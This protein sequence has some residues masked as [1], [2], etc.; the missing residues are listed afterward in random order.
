MKKLFGGILLALCASFFPVSS[1]LAVDY[2]IQCFQGWL[3]VP[4]TGGTYA[5]PTI[6]SFA[7]E[8]P[9]YNYANKAYIAI[10]GLDTAVW[11]QDIQIDYGGQYGPKFLGAWTSLGGA[12]APGYRAKIY[13]RWESAIG[14]YAPAIRVVGTDLNSYEVRWLT[15]G[16]WGWFAVGVG[17]GGYSSVPTTTG[18][19]L[20]S[21]YF[22]SD[23]MEV[24]YTFGGTNPPIYRCS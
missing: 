9:A 6:Q 3:N 8:P 5:G 13:R 11:V 23:Y 22:F 7:N 18:V 16:T 12:I 2:P 19:E 15:N 21:N 4:P 1:A 24:S 10:K 20:D 17:T 14:H